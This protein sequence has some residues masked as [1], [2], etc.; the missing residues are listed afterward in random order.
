MVEPYGTFTVFP[1]VARFTGE[2]GLAGAIRWA[3]KCAAN[4]PGM[5]KI[6]NEFGTT[7]GEY[8]GLLQVS[9]VA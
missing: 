9:A 4:G 6:V 8:Q 3:K 2:H 7:L 1:T 5:F